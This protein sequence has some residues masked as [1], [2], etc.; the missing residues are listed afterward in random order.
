M[1]YE[2]R[3]FQESRQEMLEYFYSL[4]GNDSYYDT[5][6][7]PS[8]HDTHQDHRVVAEEAFRAFKFQNIISWETPWNNLSF[9]PNYFVP[10][11]NGELRRK[12]EAVSMYKS[13]AHRF[14]FKEDYIRS[15]ARMRG[16]QINHQYAEAYEVVRIIQ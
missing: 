11:G 13:Q 3:L 14:Y 8:V 12:I 6:F 1:E 7:I 4:G 9:S 15:W 2:T 16:G 5:V 10:F